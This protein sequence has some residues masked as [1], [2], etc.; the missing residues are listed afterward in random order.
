[1]MQNKE[2]KHFNV[3][4]LMYMDFFII[5]AAKLKEYGNEV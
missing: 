2:K 5:F 3:Y 4:I 1:M